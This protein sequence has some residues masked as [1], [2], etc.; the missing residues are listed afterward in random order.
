MP[1][2]TVPSLSRRSHSWDWVYFRSTGIL[3]MTSSS[4]RLHDSACDA[5]CDSNAFRSMQA[6]PLRTNGGLTTFTSIRLLRRA[7]LQGRPIASLHRRASA[8]A[9]PSVGENPPLVISP[10]G[11]PSS[12]FFLFL[13]FL[14]LFFCFWSLFF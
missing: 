9:L 11:S 1:T 12:F 4:C 8:M 14:F 2:V 6:L 7:T 3:L 5:L 10:S 13:C